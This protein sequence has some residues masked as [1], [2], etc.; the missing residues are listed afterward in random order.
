MALWHSIVSQ[1]QLPD[2]EI[3]P[4]T[5]AMWQRLLDQDEQQPQLLE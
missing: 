2:S 5:L 1:E 3:D 4:E